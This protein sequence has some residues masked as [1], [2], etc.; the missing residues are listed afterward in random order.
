MS[1]DAAGEIEFQEHHEDLCRVQARMMYEVVDRGRR[2]AQCFDDLF[3][4][5]FTRRWSGG[6][7]R[8]FGERSSRRRGRFN[9]GRHLVQYVPRLGDEDGAVLE[10]AVAARGPGIEW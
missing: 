3:A 7:I 10:Q 1:F 2:R 8:W 9:Q 4:F 6:E 5:A